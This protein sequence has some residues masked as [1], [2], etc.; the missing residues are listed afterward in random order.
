MSKPDRLSALISRFE[1]KANIVSDIRDANLFLFGCVASGALS[2][3]VFWP[4]KPEAVDVMAEE[5]IVAAVIDMGGEG[6]PLVRALPEQIS[7]TVDQARSV[8]DISQLILGEIVEARCGRTTTIQRLFEVLVVILLRHAI[9]S[10][11]DKKGLIAGLADDR[12]CRAI[13]AIH[14]RPEFEWHIEDLADVAGLSRS[15]FM[16]RFKQCV[17]QNPAQYLREWRLALVCKD[18]DRGERVKAVALRYG[19]RSQEALSRAFSKQYHCSPSQYRM[20]AR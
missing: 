20:Q 6:N 18:L 19:Y 8:Q 11:V 7:L 10:H 4:V 1:L 2:R 16:E 5:L 3:I 9:Q 15:Q 14:E 13:V 12:I 17:G